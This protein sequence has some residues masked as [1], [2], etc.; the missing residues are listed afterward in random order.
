[1]R[2]TQAGM[3]LTVA[4]SGCL[5]LGCESSLWRHSYSEDPLL[6]SKKSV[7]GKADAS[8]PV[9]VA[10]AEPAAPPLPPTALACASPVSTEQPRAPAA[11]TTRPALSSDVSIAM[12]KAPLSVSP[13]VRSREVSGTPATTVV[14]RRVSGDYGHA[15]D[16]SWLQGILDKSSG[17]QLELRYADATLEEKW[18]G[19]VCLQ[20]DPRLHSFQ[21][22]D[23]LMIDGELLPGS[24]PSAKMTGN[25]YPR[26]HVRVV[27]LVRGN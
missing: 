22:G 1:M 15:P 17:G 8:G 5:A 9:L 27:R 19:K 16:Y 4:W 2:R 13:A 24:D 18:G 11:P 3:W 7:P 26:Y 10:Q 6:L 21:S 25:H 20:D 14:Q 23:I 12:A